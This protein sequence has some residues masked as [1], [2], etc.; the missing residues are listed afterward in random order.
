M[1]AY[2]IDGRDIVFVEVSD[3]PEDRYYAAAP[4]E[5]GQYDLFCDVVDEL[6]S[7]DSEPNF[8][9]RLHYAIVHGVLKDILPVNEAVRHAMNYREFVAMART[10]KQGGIIEIKPVH[11]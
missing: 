6:D 3:T 5:D 10:P 7:D 8:D 4:A 1:K 11:F 9:G 2:Y